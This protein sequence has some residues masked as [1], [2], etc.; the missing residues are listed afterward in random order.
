LKKANQKF[1]EELKKFSR[2]LDMNL[3]TAK[4]RAPDI[5]R[6]HVSESVLKGF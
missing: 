5:E 3:D 4:I 2:E 1:L 6:E